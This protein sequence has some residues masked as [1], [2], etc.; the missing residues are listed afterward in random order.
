[1]VLIKH[2]PNSPLNEDSLII[3]WSDDGNGELRRVRCRVFRQPLRAKG[4]RLVISKMIKLI[5]MAGK[6][7]VKKQVKRNEKR[8]PARLESRPIAES[9]PSVVVPNHSTDI[10]ESLSDAG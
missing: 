1:M 4:P 5:P 8:A 3:T 10:A 7:Q 9:E 6:Q 2:T